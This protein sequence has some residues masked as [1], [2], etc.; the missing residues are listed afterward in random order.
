MPFPGQ[1]HHE[2]SERCVRN[3][4]SSD[5]RLVLKRKRTVVLFSRR[6]SVDVDDK[7]E[8]ILVLVDCE[9]RRVEEQ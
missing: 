5:E 7:I 6:N 2:Y 8:R 1:R 4:R 9:A 3:R